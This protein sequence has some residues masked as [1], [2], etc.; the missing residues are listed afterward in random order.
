[1]S[2]FHVAVTWLYF[3]AQWGSGK[4]EASLELVLLPYAMILIGNYVCSSCH[5]IFS[6]SEMISGVSTC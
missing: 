3:L 4:F 5:C 2:T 1:M 6:F